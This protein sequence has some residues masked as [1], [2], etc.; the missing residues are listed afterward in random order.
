MLRQPLRTEL[1][2]AAAIAAKAGLG[3]VRPEVLHL[4][5][6]TTVRLTPW[7]I[8]ARIA[9]R[10]SLHDFEHEARRELTIADHLARR[11]APSVRPAREIAPGPYLEQNCA[12]TLWEF[13]EG[14]PPATEADDCMAAASLR[15]FHSALADVSIGL[16]SFVSKVESCEMILVDPAQAPNLEAS[17]RRF[18]RVL[19]DRLRS[20]L[21]GIGGA[22]QPLH[23]DAHRA[24]AIVTKAGAIWMD[25]ESVC[26]GPIEWD[27][28]FLPT[29]TW[30]EF[31][32]IDATLIDL[33][34]DVRSLCVTTW[35]WA[36]LD[37]S[38]ATKEAAIHHLTKLRGRFG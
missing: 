36:E 31:R 24:N 6:H 30:Q 25:L 27:I 17:D 7:P 16:P 32:A 23:G 2:V 29:A 5:S 37:R 12:V 8:V 33:L 10:A 21:N 3:A 9:S 11:K 19:Y 20:D 15:E 4:G 14:R 35:C 34:A 38:P 26:V 22:W 18:L 13:V 28:G 1:R